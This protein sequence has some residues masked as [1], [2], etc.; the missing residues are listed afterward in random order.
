[1]PI[2]WSYLLRNYLKVFSLCVTGFISV[3]L[4]T[5]FQTVARFAATGASKLVVLKF[6][7]LQIPF[8]LPLAIPISCLIAAFLLFQKMSRSKELTAIRMSGL[9]FI[10]M[11]FPLLITAVLFALLNF[12][13]VSELTPKC[14][15]LSK[16]LAYEMTAANPLCLL[17]KDTLIKLKNT[18]VDMQ[19]LKSGKYAEDVFFITR[20]L[21]NQRIGVMLAKKLSLN[22][23]KLIGSN[24]TFISSADSKQSD[25]FDHLVI[26]NQAEMQTEADEL[27]QYLHS[28][29][30]SLSFENLNLRMLLAKNELENGVG[31]PL[32]IHVISEISRRLSLGIGAFTFT[33][34][35]I[36]CGMEISRQLKLK[37]ILWASSFLVIYLVCFVIAKSVR[38][39]HLQSTLFYL[40]PHPLILIF[41]LYN[42]KRIARGAE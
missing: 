24:V 23:Q 16:M 6:V 10:P 21:S 27:S 39:N 11:T 1:M 29:G 5:R 35:G 32:D 2:L 25:G 40:A 14:R 15:A 17:Q 26:E 38:H 13:V 4:V 42:F 37:G 20:T 12:T 36:A 19:V 33:L 9:G 18:Y 34:L 7:L 28:S 30:W 8:I 41:C 22:D 3:L 31:A